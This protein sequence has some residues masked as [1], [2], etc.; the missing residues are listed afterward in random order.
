MI[1]GIALFASFRNEF[2]I[3]PMQLIN[4]SDIREEKRPLHLWK[5]L[6]LAG[7]DLESR[8]TEANMIILLNDLTFVSN[9]R[10]EGEKV[11]VK[12]VRVRG[13]FLQT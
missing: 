12:V 8:A 7:I 10:T 3:V 1:Y 2:L 5:E 4:A 9:W 11:S 6:R 13:A